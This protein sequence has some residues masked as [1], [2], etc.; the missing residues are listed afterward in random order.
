MWTGY[1]EGG[2][3]YKSSRLRSRGCRNVEKHRQQSKIKLDECEKKVD[4]RKKLSPFSTEKEF[5]NLFH[6][7]INKKSTKKFFIKKRNSLPKREN[8]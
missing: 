2:N 1:K 5:Y 3:V 7:V 4:K 8:N 6:R